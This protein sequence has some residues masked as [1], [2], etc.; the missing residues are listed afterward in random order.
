MSKVKG[1]AWYRGGQ[2]FLQVP[3]KRTVVDASLADLMNIKAGYA[4]EVEV[5]EVILPP[6]EQPSE[7][8]G[9]AG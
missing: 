4:A 3:G 2:L 6:P 7:T 8:D 1:Q 9:G 5:E